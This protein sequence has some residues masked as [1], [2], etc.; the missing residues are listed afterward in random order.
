MENDGSCMMEND[1]SC[2]MENEFRSCGRPKL[3]VESSS[4]Q[5]CTSPSYTTKPIICRKGTF[6][7]WV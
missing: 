7:L 6:N 1:G 2:M 4:V 3:E 5:E